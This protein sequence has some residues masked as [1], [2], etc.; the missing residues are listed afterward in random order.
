VAAEHTTA[1]DDA[2]AK[3][4]AVSQPQP[5]KADSAGERREPE[6]D[7]R[8]GPGAAGNGSERSAGSGSEGQ[9]QPPGSAGSDSVQVVPGIARYHRSDCLLIR[10]L[11]A[12]DLDVMTA[13]E[14]TASG[15]VPCKACKPEAVTAQA[16]TV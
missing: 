3:P 15:C 16:G 9:K 11:T 2:E 7:T 8:S 1:S 4:A 10:F 5:A 14:A 6:P 13:A 12:D